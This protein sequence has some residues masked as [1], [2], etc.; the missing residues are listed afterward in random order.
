[1]TAHTRS[2]GRAVGSRAHCN[3]LPDVAVLTRRIPYQSVRRRRIRHWFLLLMRL[4]AL[5]LP[6]AQM[7]RA[8]VYRL[9]DHAR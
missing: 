4:T 2:G 6:E 7:D 8:E 1:M 3:G 5:A 9:P